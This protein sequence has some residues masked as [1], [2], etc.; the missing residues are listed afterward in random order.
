VTIPDEIE[1]RII[2]KAAYV[3]EA[4]TILSEKQSLDRT[5]YQSDREQRA[6]VEREFQTAIEAC[7][8]I[9]PSHT[10]GVSAVTPRVPQ[11]RADQPLRRSRRRS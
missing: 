7:I 10:V 6:I 9:T 8:D 3:E 5:T 11:E 4:V 1:A 2:D